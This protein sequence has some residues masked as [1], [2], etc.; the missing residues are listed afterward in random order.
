MIIH[1]KE[2]EID[3]KI[4]NSIDDGNYLLN[5]MFA[6]KI[7]FLFNLIFDNY[8]HIDLILNHENQSI[9]NG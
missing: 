8:Q 5:F 3:Y 9:K 2:I 7:N 1:S 4:Y 6:L